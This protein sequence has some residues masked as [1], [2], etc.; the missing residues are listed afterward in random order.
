MPY[1]NLTRKKNRSFC[2]KEIKDLTSCYIFFPDTTLATLSITAYAY[3]QKILSMCRM[4][5]TCNTKFYNKMFHKFKDKGKRS[6]AVLSSY[7][8]L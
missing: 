6:M 4:Q 5:F 2:Q 8:E 3:Y 1:L 7:D